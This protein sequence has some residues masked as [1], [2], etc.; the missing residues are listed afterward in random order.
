MKLN[1]TVGSDH[2]T[3]SE[4]IQF[5]SSDFSY[6]QNGVQ[7]RDQFLCALNEKKTK[8]ANRF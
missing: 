3:D 4:I 6:L 7:D 8:S 5:T 2:V 1:S